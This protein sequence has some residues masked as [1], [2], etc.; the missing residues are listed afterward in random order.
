M[1]DCG[2]W[3]NCSRRDT[4]KS[5]DIARGGPIPE[6]QPEPEAPSLMK[7]FVKNSLLGLAFWAVVGMISASRGMIDLAFKD[8]DKK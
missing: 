7:R 1:A 5:D 4:M 8:R 6:P 3:L 2:A